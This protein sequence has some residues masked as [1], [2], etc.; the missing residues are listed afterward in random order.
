MIDENKIKEEEQKILNS[1]IN[2]LDNKLLELDSSLEQ[3][4]LDR[5]K[6]TVKSLPEAY[7]ALLQDNH[8]IKKTKENRKD[9]VIAK[10]QLGARTFSWTK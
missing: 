10:D 4:E 2:E 8:H 9:F 7:G 3:Y 6:E 5:K 1:L